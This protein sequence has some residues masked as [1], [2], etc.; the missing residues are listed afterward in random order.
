MYCMAVG[1][2]LVQD[3][4]LF[5]LNIF[6]FWHG[7]VIK[8]CILYY[9]WAECTGNTL[10]SRKV[11]EFIAYEIFIFHNY[12]GRQARMKEFNVKNFSVL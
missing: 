9:K 12:E 6:G 2:S 7:N 10:L 8:S 4:F 1:I 5:V 3:Y 11:G